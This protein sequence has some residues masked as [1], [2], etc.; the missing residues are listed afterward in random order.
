MDTTVPTGIKVTESPYWITVHRRS[1]FRRLHK[2]GV[3]SCHVQP[4]SCREVREVWELSPEVADAICKVCAKE[5]QKTQA[6]EEEASSSSS[7]SS[8]SASRSDFGWA[9]PQQHVVNTEGSSWGVVTEG[10]NF[11]AEVHEIED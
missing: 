8:S 11:E 4:W 9:P 3:L 5:I 1:G 10:Q 6:G 7:G 2:R